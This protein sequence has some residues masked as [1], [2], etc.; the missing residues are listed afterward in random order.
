MEEYDIYNVC[1]PGVCD[2]FKLK[3]TRYV[4]LYGLYKYISTL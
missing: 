4:G 1:R 3:K 2:D